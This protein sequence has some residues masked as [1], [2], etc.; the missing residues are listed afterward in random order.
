MENM[1]DEEFPPK[2][3][4]GGELYQNL[5]FPEQCCFSTRNNLTPKEKDPRENNLAKKKQMRKIL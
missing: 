1:N 2:C 3:G 4:A 5:I